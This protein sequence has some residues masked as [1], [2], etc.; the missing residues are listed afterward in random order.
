MIKLKDI[1][2]TETAS[3]RAMRDS[4]EGASKSFVRDFKKAFTKSSKEYGIFSRNIW[5]C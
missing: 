2:V 3:T 5:W 4:K 1:L